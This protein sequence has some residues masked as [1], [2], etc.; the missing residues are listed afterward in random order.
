MLYDQRKKLIQDGFRLAKRNATCRI[1]GESI[2]AG[3][4]M[5]SYLSHGSRDTSGQLCIKCVEMMAT[6]VNEKLENR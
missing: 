1:C 2:P 4:E 5:L 3:T 6:I